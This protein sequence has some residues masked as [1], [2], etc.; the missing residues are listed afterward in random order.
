[1]AAL[2]AGNLLEFPNNLKVMGEWMPAASETSVPSPTDMAFNY[3]NGEMDSPDPMD[4]KPMGTLV[5]SHSTLSV[6]VWV[7]EQ[8]AANIRQLDVTANTLSVYRVV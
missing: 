7:T 8:N 5:Q 3:L 6:Y 1:M 4:G 2:Y